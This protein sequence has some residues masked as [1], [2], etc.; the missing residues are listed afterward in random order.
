MSHKVRTT[1]V[2][3]G[4][5]AVA[6]VL[7]LGRPFDPH[8]ADAEPRRATGEDID[9]ERPRFAERRR[10]RHAMVRRS[11]ERRGISDPAVLDAMRRV[12][13]HEFVRARDERRAYYD[14]ALPI[15]HGQTISQ[16][17]VVAYMTEKL[18]LKPGDKVLEVGTGSGYQAAVLSELTPHVWT[19]EI[20]PA[21]AEQA[22]K[23][24]ERLG[25]ET[26]ACKTGD[27]YYGW[28]EHA[29]FDAI[30][31]TC[32]AGTVPPPLLKQLKPG[33]RMCIPVGPPGAVQH[34]V[35][36]TRDDE[37]ELRSRSL[38]PVRFVPLRHSDR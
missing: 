14:T 28:P 5:A 25:Y 33:G 4:L 36:V 7:L 17:Y 24:L 26:I 3:A 9:W 27:G 10:E 6:G 1:L 32:A 8:A 23:R 16:P 18:G 34:L 20:I 13:R 22:E 12:P 11:I 21:L 30:I 38:I 37:G 19:I 35:L 2:L 15:G 29:P 31:V